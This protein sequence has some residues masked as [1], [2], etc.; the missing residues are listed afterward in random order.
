MLRYLRSG[1]LLS[2]VAV[3]ERLDVQYPTPAARSDWQ[4]Q[5]FNSA[6]SEIVRNVPYYSAA[7][8][9]RRLPTSFASW[10]EFREQV[11]PTNREQLRDELV[12]RTSRRRPADAYRSTGGSTAQPLRFPCWKTEAS[13]SAV[14]AWQA[15]SWL[16]IAP[17]DRLFLL[18]G[19][20]HLFGTGWTGA[21]RRVERR[22][23]DYV[24]G[25]CRWPAY[26]LTP[27]ALQRAAKRLLEFRPAYL[28][29]YSVA[30]DRFAEANQ[31]R[32]NELHSLALKA[33]IATAE[34]FPT[35]ASR[36]RIAALF[37]C[38]VLMEYGA[39]E[40]GVLAQETR[41]GHYR[42]LWQNYLLETEVASETSDPREL[43]VT[44][45]YPRC[46]PLVR[47]RLGDQVEPDHA[48]PIVTTIRRVAGRCNDLIRL[49]NGDVIHSEAIAHIVRDFPDVLGYQAV[50]KADDGLEL[51]LRTRG[52]L[53]DDLTGRLRQRLRLLGEALGAAEIC[54]TDRMTQTVAGKTPTVVRADSH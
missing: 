26:D 6:W 49:R 28:I 29:G 47:Y 35:T 54:Q 45:L 53:S 30:L 19:H 5:Q 18:W 51:R 44:S 11:K 22:A 3:A 2:H 25:Y 52:P 24:L 4:L 37:D 17:T 41:E 10:A 27:T 20:S 7:A 14:A 50:L 13:V 9:E 34:A 42:T 43:L 8:A 38:P 15:R 46:L 40:T 31:H 39:V 21:L 1:K 36:S 12:Q 23:R 33:V 32:A 16:G 48:G